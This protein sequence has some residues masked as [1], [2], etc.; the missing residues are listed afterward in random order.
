Y[1]LVDPR[2]MKAKLIEAGVMGVVSSWSPAERYMPDATAAVES[3]SDAPGQPGFFEGD[4]P[5]PAM[6]ISPEMGVEL[7]VL[8]DR[9]NVRVKMIIDAKHYA[10]GLPVTCGYIDASLQEEIVAVC[11]TQ[12]MGANAC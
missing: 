4:I 7:D 6:M 9:G 12:R 2:S 5:L 10:A 1:I 11:S 3:W 8:F